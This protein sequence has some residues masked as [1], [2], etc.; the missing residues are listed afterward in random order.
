MPGLTFSMRFSGTRIAIGSPLNALTDE[1]LWAR[2]ADFDGPLISPCLLEGGNGQGKSLL[3]KSLTG[4]I[5]I[6]GKARVTSGRASGRARLLFQDVITQTL[7][8]SFGAILNSVGNGRRGQAAELYQQL[9]Y[10]GVVVLA[11]GYFVFEAVIYPLIAK[12]IPF[13]AVTDLK[14]AIAEIVPNLLQGI[15]SAVIAFGVCRIFQG[16]D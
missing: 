8:R 6:R 14:A 12:V 10:W 2:V 1:P 13:F 11:T 3:A 7:L 15:I 4:A 16:Q 5:A 9:W